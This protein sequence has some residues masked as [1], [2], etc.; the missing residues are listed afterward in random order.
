MAKSSHNLIVFSLL[1]FL[2]AGVVSGCSQNSYPSDKIEQALIEICKKE[3]GVENIKVK[4]RGS[5]IGV[6]LPLKKLFA[7]DFKEAILSGKVD[8]VE[9]LFEPSQDAMDKVEDV[10]FTIS[11][12]ILSTDRKLD[13]YV[14]QAT[15]VENTGLEL[16]LKGYVDDI[17]RVRVWDVSRDEYRKRVIHELKLNQT[18][19]WQKPIQGFF[20][21]L[22]GLSPE[23]IQSK[24]FEPKLSTEIIPK[25]FYEVVDLKATL[26]DISH[27][28]IQ[29]IRG[30]ELSR[31]SAVVYVKVLPELST[32]FSA[33]VSLRDLEYLFILE[34]K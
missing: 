29:E 1:T 25:M 3:Y 30:M 19:L 6:F 5:T 7:T 8:N 28:K 27:W 32:E 10:L 14:L 34:L 21:D 20:K 12:V 15:D 26:T 22:L 33:A 31:R 2:A 13:F 4:I 9:N 17:K 18:V 11:R 23:E 16:I 24:Y